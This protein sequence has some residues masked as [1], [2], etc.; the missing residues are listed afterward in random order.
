[1]KRDEDKLTVA[2]LDELCRAYMDCRLSVL[3][4]AELEYILSHTTLTSANIEDV[5]SLMGIPYSPESLSEP[6][7][8]PTRNKKKIWNWRSFSAAASI[9]AI[10]FSVTFYFMSGSISKATDNDFYV[11]AYNHGKQLNE[12]E[13]LT[14]TA[15]AMAKADSLMKAAAMMEDNFINKANALIQITTN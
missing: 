6:S 14:S 12:A 1:M 9:I 13:A 2:E 15:I 8:T 10:L 11:V 3:E 5:R 7:L 4:E